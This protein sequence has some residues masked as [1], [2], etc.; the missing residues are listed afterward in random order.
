M[1]GGFALIAWPA[2][3]GNSGITTFLINHDGVVFSKDLGP[4]TVKIASRATAF[5]RTIR[6]RE[7]RGRWR[8]KIG[9]A[10][11]LFLRHLLPPLLR[12]KPS[13]VTV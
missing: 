6:G 13:S 8:R 3:Y 4:D 1:I 12:S 7:S 10:T 11:A 5:N 9:T 2:E